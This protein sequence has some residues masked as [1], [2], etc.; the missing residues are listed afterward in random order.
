MKPLLNHP[1]FYIRHC[2]KPQQKH[3]Y[4]SIEDDGTVTIRTP[5]NNSDLLQK[6]VQKK[7]HWILQR[8]ERMTQRQSA[9]LGETLYY[10]GRLYSID[11]DIAI[12]L[13]RA[14]SRLRVVNSK[15][16]QRCYDHFYK[17]ACI[18]YLPQRIAYFSDVMALYPSE[19]H[20]RK[21]KRRWG[22]CDSKK[23]ITFNSAVMKL[24]LKQIDYI[25][26]HELAHLQHMNHAPSF[27][28]LV[29]QYC[30]N[31]RSIEQELRRLRP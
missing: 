29:Q 24:S 7:E 23:K 26:I 1:H 11:S 5:I 3:T 19:I 15:H 31:A 25:V 22:S 14:V 4:I 30:H 13:K 6:I 20:Y 18:D 16:L 12:P 28:R 10:L 17:H 8:L 27:H 21:M 9:V 2:Y